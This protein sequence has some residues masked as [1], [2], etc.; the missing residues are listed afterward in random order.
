MIQL[1]SAYQSVLS[2]SDTTMKSSSGQFQAK[3]SESTQ[4]SDPSQAIQSRQDKADAGYE[5]PKSSV[6]VKLEGTSEP[7]FDENTP[8]NFMNYSKTFEDNVVALKN[9][10]EHKSATQDGAD[11]MEPALMKKDDAQALTQK[12]SEEVA[13]NKEIYVRS[14]SSTMPEMA[15]SMI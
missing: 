2:S 4:N 5:A 3:A 9:A 12:I 7:D 13:K 6:A 8:S 14:Q 11:T 15:L 1:T 10:V